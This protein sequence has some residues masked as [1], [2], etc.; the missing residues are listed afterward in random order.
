MESALEQLVCARFCDGR[1]APPALRTRVGWGD[2]AWLIG[3]P[4]LVWLLPRGGG[5]MRVFFPIIIFLLYLSLFHSLY[6]R[7]LMRI[8]ILT[9]LGGMC[10]SIYLM[11]NS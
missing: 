6:A 7:R 11:H 3:W 8:P 9:I 5:T 1:G 10:Y 4:L 2:F